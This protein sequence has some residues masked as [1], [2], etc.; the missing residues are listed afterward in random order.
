MSGARGT[1]GTSRWVKLPEVDL[2]GEVHYV[3]HGGPEGAPAVVLVHGLGGS[4]ANWTAM[5]PMLTPTYRVLALDLAGFGLTAG[6]PGAA[7]VKRNRLLL[8]GF[9]AEVVGEPAVLVGS[10]MGGLISALQAT[11][12]PATVRALALFDP[13]LPFRPAL[14][15][16]LTLST[17][18]QLG[19][20]LPV[21]RY[22]MR[23]HGPV[24]PEQATERATNRLLRLVTADPGR[25]PARIID[26]HIAL[27]HRRHE[28]P[29]T[30]ADL[31]LAA[32]SLGW[33]MFRRR[34]FAAMLRRLRL[35]VL[36]VHGDSDRLI[37]VAAARAAAAANPGWRFELG[38]GV[39]H[40]PMV[41]APA[42]TAGLLLDW[43]PAAL[44]QN[45]ALEQDSTRTR[46]SVRETGGGG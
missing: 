17:F 4:H 7:T 25:I 40:V 39:G 35:P 45:G 22:L 36:L 43:L 24:T 28:I 27:A 19:L 5:A 31:L 23:R 32:R 8:H 42:W 16:R 6:S 37:P 9:L 3:D 18:V 29:N 30:E 44:E 38:V 20:P 41:E 34:E 46:E 33:M 1:A 2:D 14:P 15:D 11:Q 21:R 13:A 26:E 12:E 10:S